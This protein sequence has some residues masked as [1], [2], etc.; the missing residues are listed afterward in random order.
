VK[1]VQL[2]ILDTVAGVYSRPF[3]ARSD[4]EGMRIFAQMCEKDETV[5]KSPSD[6]RLYR[7]GSFDEVSGELEGGSPR[8]LLAGSQHLEMTFEN[9][10]KQPGRLR[11]F[12]QRKGS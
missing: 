3:T 6:Y 2:T 5:S 11:R 9:G 1:L 8:Q 10:R 4:A 12:L 7:V